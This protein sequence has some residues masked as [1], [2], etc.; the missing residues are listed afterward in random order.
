MWKG[1]A[2]QWPLSLPLKPSILCQN[3]PEGTGRDRV[4]PRKRAH[5]NG[6]CL[7]E[8]QIRKV[9]DAPIY[10]P[11]DGHLERGRTAMAAFPNQ[12]NGVAIECMKILE[13][14]AYRNG[15]IPRSSRWTGK[16]GECSEEPTG[17]ELKRGRTAMAAFPDQVPYHA[18]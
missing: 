6:R 16:E 14:E 18:G 11:K 3:K 12:G 7:F 1:G 9:P 13:R 2:P 10:N 17:K 8:G 5:R 4:D 15:R